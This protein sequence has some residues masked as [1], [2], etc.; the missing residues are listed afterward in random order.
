MTAALTDLTVSMPVF[1]SDHA[2]DRFIQRFRHH[3]SVEGLL[4]AFGRSRVVEWTQL[5]AEAEHCGRPLRL[6][7]DGFFRRDDLTGCLFVMRR[8]PN[9]GFRLVVVTVHPFRRP[10][11]FERYE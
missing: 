7:R 11:G 3:A 6:T 1:M 8:P 2:V 10:A 9:G 4:A 5:R